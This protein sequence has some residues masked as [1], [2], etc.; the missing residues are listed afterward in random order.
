MSISYASQSSIVVK[1]AHEPLDVK[2]WQDLMMVYIGLRDEQTI[3]SLQVIVRCVSQLAEG[4]ENG[5]LRL[6]PSQ[7]ALVAAMASRPNDPEIL[8][9]AGLMFLNEFKIPATASKFFVRGLEV[10]PHDSELARLSSQTIQQTTTKNERVDAF[11]KKQKTGAVPPISVAPAEPLNAR[12]AISRSVRIDPRILEKIKNREPVQSPNP[13]RRSAAIQPPTTANQLAMGLAGAN[14]N[15]PPTFPSV[16]LPS[17]KTPPPSP[18]KIPP[19]PPAMGLEKP[20][21]HG[22]PART[23]TRSIAPKSEIDSVE[24]AHAAAVQAIANGQLQEAYNFLKSATKTHVRLPSSS[25]TWNDL[26]LT[27]HQRGDRA[28][29]IDCYRHAVTAKPDFV[30]GWFNL[31]AT[32][33]EDGQSDQAFAAYDEVVLLDPLHAKGWCNMGV[34]CFECADY[35]QA[36]YCCEQAVTAKPDYGKAW[37]NLGVS[38]S[39]LGRMDEASFAFEKA[40]SIRPDLSETWFRLGSIYFDRGDFLRA[41]EAFEK[42]TEKNPVHWDAWCYLALT[43]IRLGSLPQAHE[44][45]D[46]LSVE[47][48][49]CQLLGVA[50]NEL[51][52]SMRREGNYVGAIEV[53]LRAIE[54]RPGVAEVWFNMGVAMDKSGQT[55]GALKSFRQAVR[56]KPELTAAWNNLGTIYMEQNLPKEA[57]EVFQQII[58]L[59]PE[60]ANGWFNL[61]MA[62]EKIGQQEEANRCFETAKTLESKQAQESAAQAQG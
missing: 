17:P 40:V 21:I 50:W 27:A 59:E 10:A 56:L 58:Q 29:A 20:R 15:I 53:F 2:H 19:N 24:A 49:E 22:T 61:G 11:L 60:Y 31:G 36:V 62:L 33:Q 23:T 25:S 43:R 39:V 4:Q 18:P 46:R 12:T 41:E 44:I 9:R 30:D 16:S 26:G 7:K 52:V 6:T 42:T 45:C 34:L 8:K 54:W 14:Q 55:Q 1:I 47:A 32:L 48:P 3:A 35:E 13:V 5:E 37:D 51:G 38:L 57:V 28:L